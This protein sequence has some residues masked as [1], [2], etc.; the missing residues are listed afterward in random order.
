MR[1][2]ISFESLN[3]KIILPVHYN[4]YIQSLIYRI[5][6][7]IL[8]TKLH[9]IG[10]KFEK[11]SF[12]FFTFSRILEKGEK[13]RLKDQDFLIFKNSI[14]FI[15]SS[16][17]E[18]IVSDLGEKSIK[19]R[20]FNLLKNRIYLS[21]IRVFMTP[22]LETPLKIK[23]LSPVTIHST[24]TLNNG[25]KRSIYYKPIEK[26]FNSLITQNL[27]KKFKALYGREPENKNLEIKPVYFSIKSNFHL[28]KFKNTP[29]EA[30]DGIYELNGSQ[31]LINLSYETGLGDRNSEGFGLWEIYK[32]GEKNVRC[33]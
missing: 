2:E 29:I 11:R 12:K 30:Y 26:S 25:N 24:I 32:G 13:V 18:E 17:K 4:F 10:F 22:R 6:S 16:P 27:I 7:P 19:E 20:E 21:K 28:I 9:N 5:F 15:F 23:F 33:Y 1:I 31:E 8:A 14:S 3:G